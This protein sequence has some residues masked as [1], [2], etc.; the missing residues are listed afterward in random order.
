MVNEFPKLHSSGDMEARRCRNSGS[1]EMRIEKN[2]NYE[3]TAPVLTLHSSSIDDVS[4]V[5][6][7][8]TAF[9]GSRNSVSPASDTAPVRHVDD[10]IIRASLS[11]PP[12][13]VSTPVTTSF[14]Q[15][16]PVTSSSHTRSHQFAASSIFRLPS[17]L[18]ENDPPVTI[19]FWKKNSI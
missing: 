12:R 10:Q 14:F 18:Q 16:G 7:E 17:V 5:W 8:G 1:V 13:A 9:V 2:R 15:Y 4:C 3:V 11:V 6:A 19:C